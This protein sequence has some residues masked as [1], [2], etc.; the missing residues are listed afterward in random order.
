MTEKKT[1]PTRTQMIIWSIPGVVAILLT[2]AALIYG[3]GAPIGFGGML[4]GF[5]YF[6]IRYSEASK[7][8]PSQ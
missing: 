6:M 3:K 7:D 8:M 1:R 4:V 5:L 2:I